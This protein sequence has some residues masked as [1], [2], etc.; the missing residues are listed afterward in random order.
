MFGRILRLLIVFTLVAGASLNSQIAHADSDSDE[1]L[2]NTLLI[3]GLGIG[4]VACLYGACS[5]DES[6][7]ST[8]RQ[9]SNYQPKYSCSFCCEGSFGSCRSESRRV[10]TPHSNSID[11]QNYVSETYEKYCKQFPFYA[12][13]GGQASV[14]YPNCDPWWELNPIKPRPVSSHHII[15]EKRAMSDNRTLTIKCDDSDCRTVYEVQAVLTTFQNTGFTQCPSCYEEMYVQDKG[16]P[17]GLLSVNN[18]TRKIVGKWW[19]DEDVIRMLGLQGWKALEDGA[20]R[21]FQ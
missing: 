3:F 20:C 10:E 5:D 12:S 18:N 21:C 9:S 8:P 14:S 15:K 4:L 13:G 16:Y 6:S 1:A 11:A 19:S 2:G 7:D 17:G